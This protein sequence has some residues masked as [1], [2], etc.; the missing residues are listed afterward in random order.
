MNDNGSSDEES[1]FETLLSPYVVNNIVQPEDPGQPEDTE[2]SDFDDMPALLS[3]YP[4]YVDNNIVQPE[5]PV[6]P[7]EDSDFADMPELIPIDSDLDDQPEL[8]PT[9]D[10]WVLKL[11]YLKGI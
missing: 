9:E 6:Q 3:T 1:D 7:E 11:R 10:I 2:D 8:I 4:P 5:D